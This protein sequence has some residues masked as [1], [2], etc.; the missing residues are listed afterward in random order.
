MKFLLGRFTGI[1][2]V[3]S[4]LA[5]VSPG[6]LAQKK[7]VP[8]TCPD[9]NSSPLKAGDVGKNLLVTGVCFVPKGEYRY[10]YVNVVAKGQLVFM[11]AAIEFRAK[12]ILV[13]NDGAIY[14]GVDLGPDILKPALPP[15]PTIKPIGTAPGGKLVIRL[16]GEDFVK[17]DTSIQKWGGGIGIPCVTESD[18]KGEAST[19]GIPWYIWSSDGEKVVKPGSQPNTPPEFPTLPGGVQDRFY[20]YNPLT[21]DNGHA[22]NE[23]PGY[24]GSKVLAVSYGGTLA[25][26][27]KKG[28]SYDAATNADSSKSGTSWARLDRSLAK[29]SQSAE[30]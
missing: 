10:G 13:E 15:N 4:L 6:V 9:S 26:Y 20:A 11:D 8:V 30:Q 14:A 27:G 7:D 21:F 5:G 12:S 22:P 23:Q 18:K 24:F 25:L 17:P 19:C 16:Y 29:D 3:A 1:V 2:F 28:A